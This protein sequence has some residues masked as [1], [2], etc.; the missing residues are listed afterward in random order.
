[1]TDVRPAFRSLNVSKPGV[2]RRLAL[3]SLT[4]LAMPSAVRAGTIDTFVLAVGGQAILGPNFECATFIAPSAVREVFGAGVSLPTDGLATCGVGGD[5]RSTTGTSGT[6]SDSMSFSSVFNGSSN[7]FTGSASATAQYGS[8][9]V[10]AHSTF[11]GPMNSFIVEG[12]EAYSSFHA[13]GL[14]PNTLADTVRF[15]FTVD[16]NLSVNVAPPFYSASDVQVAYQLDSG[17]IY[18]LMHGLVSDSVSTPFIGSGTGAPVSGFTLAP[19]SLSGSGAFN[20]F[21]LAIVPGAPFDLS[22]FMFAY[23]IPAPGAVNEANFLT[24]ANL[25]GIQLFSGGQAIPDFLITSDFGVVFGP[26]G[27]IQSNGSAAEPAT[28]LLLGAGM[29]LV[30]RLRRQRSGKRQP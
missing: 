22:L 23:T 28:M 18:T 7:A 1:M 11:D 25:T 2:Y 26:N 30:A 4:V 29:V 17:P 20:T 19:G 10:A 9:G 14:Q 5:L 27:V 24:T 3:C 6:V 8:L 15:Q 12:A 21:D 13:T 16:G